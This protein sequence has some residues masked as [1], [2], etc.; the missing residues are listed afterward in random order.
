MKITLTQRNVLANLVG[1][2]GGAVL[3]FLIL[4]LFVASLG[5]EAYGV[6]AFFLALQTALTAFD[7]GLSMTANR[8]LALMSARADSANEMRAVVRAMERFFWLL[9][10][11][12]GTLLILLAP[13]LSG[14]WLRPQQLA[15]SELTTALQMMAAAVALQWPS[16]FYA[17][18]LNGLQ[19]QTAL[20][21][22]N[23]VAAILRFPGIILLLTLTS[24]T[25]ST[26]F[27]AQ[28]G[29]S[30]V[31]TLAT[32]LAVWRFLPAADRTR[33]AA[34]IG[35]ERLRHFAA[36][37]SGFT[38]AALILT[39]LDKLLLSAYLPL[40][41]F[42]FYA[43]ASTLA[44]GLGVVAGPIYNT[45]FPRFAQLVASEAHD[46]LRHTYHHTAQLMAILLL[47]LA[48][49]L[50]LFP[51]TVLWVWTD[52]FEIAQSASGVLRLL[53]L[54]SS[55]HY[56]LW[57]PLALQLAHGWT[58]PA[59]VT[60]FLMLAVFI[61]LLLLLASWA[62]GDGA[63]LAW[64]LV[65]LLNLMLSVPWMHRRLLP[66]DLWRWCAADVILPLAPVLAVNA[67]LLLLISPADRGQGVLLLIIAVLGGWIGAMVTVPVSREWLRKA[68]GYWKHG[69]QDERA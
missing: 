41:Q 3:M 50:M 28:I 62:G 46:E 31:Q 17:G 51:E 19:R 38:A 67:G 53:A 29:V 33:P 9:A 20:N 58:R 11:G 47:P 49:V 35:W 1:Q 54:G 16:V 26:F 37:V 69:R 45:M 32:G 4:P 12:L 8:E 68:V 14:Y 18:C 55:V 61:P 34:V 5:K 48:V 44:G 22:I 43:L 64:L 65:N 24:P 7:L 2:A 21:G 36:G 39:Q 13:V 40:E 63:A 6:V 59:L 52:D 27:L 25:L 57:V 56:L 42:G 66:G 10:V 60:Y 15:Q 30:A 23:L